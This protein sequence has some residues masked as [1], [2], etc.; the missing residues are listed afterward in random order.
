MRI[1]EKIT[2]ETF[3][4]TD[5]IC[6]KCGET[7]YNSVNNVHHYFKEYIRMNESFGYN[8][9][10]F[11]DATQLECDI[12]EKCLWEFVQTFKNKDSVIK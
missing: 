9:Q 1:T 3:K 5:I 10:L 8:S 6:D 7:I 4:T 12:C 2:V 11:G